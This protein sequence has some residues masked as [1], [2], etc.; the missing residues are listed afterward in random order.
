MPVGSAAWTD[1]QPAL[2]DAAGKWIDDQDSCHVHILYSLPSSCAALEHEHGLRARRELGEAAVPHDRNRVALPAAPI[3][4]SGADDLEVELRIEIRHQRSV[5]DLGQRLPR[6]HSELR[7]DDQRQRAGLGV[8]GEGRQ[9]SR[10]LVQGL[11]PD[12]DAVAS[13]PP[14]RRQ[15]GDVADPRVI[16]VAHRLPVARLGAQAD[17]PERMTPPVL[18]AVAPALV[19]AVASRAA[20]RGER[21]GGR[22]LGERAGGPAP[23]D[24][25]HHERIVIGLHPLSVSRRRP[26]RFSGAGIPRRADRPG[27]A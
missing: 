3:R 20:A 14:H 4:R 17:L 9:R 24:E 15:A 25:V 13:R 18:E 5:P 1:G 22:E 19:V 27:R 8:A 10:L 12:E 6:A 7:G 21:G 16:E 11:H 2:G 26:V 23:H